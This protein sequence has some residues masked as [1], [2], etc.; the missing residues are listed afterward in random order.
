VLLVLAQST[1]AKAA[2]DSVERAHQAEL[3]KLGPNACPA[4]R[5]AQCCRKP[6][7]DVATTT[8][9]LEELAQA[10]Q[11]I[12]LNEKQVCTYYT[13]M[14]CNICTYVYATNGSA[15]YVV[16][17]CVLVTVRVHIWLLQCCQE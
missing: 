10:L 5:A 4:C 2:G 15:T 12:R 17:V 14:H 11:H 16:P 13:A 8:A 1:T 6:A 3:D 9:R 7:V